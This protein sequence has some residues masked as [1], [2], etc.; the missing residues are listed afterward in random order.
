VLGTTT[1]LGEFLFGGERSDLSVVR[2]ILDDVQAGRCFYCDTVMKKPGH[3]DHFI[4]WSKY[5]L[6]LGH[7][8]VVAHETCNSA[9]SDHLADAG[10]LASW[11]ERN[12]QHRDR[13]ATEFSRNGVLHDLPTSVR[14]ADWAY[15]QTF[16]ARGL[17]WAEKETMVTLTTDWRHSIVQL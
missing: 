1:D 10:F 5:P 9:K 16:E 6:D 15:Q 4:P 13:L 11:T 8:F 3:V 17:V 14:I 2:V 12:R 7:N